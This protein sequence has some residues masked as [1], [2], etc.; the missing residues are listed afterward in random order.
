MP[1]RDF[2]TSEEE[3]NEPPPEGCFQKVVHHLM[4][5]SLLIF[6][7]GSCIRNLCQMCVEIEDE[8]EANDASK[9]ASGK[10]KG[11]GEDQSP[12]K[13]QVFSPRV[14]S[15][16]V[17]LEGASD[18]KQHSYAKSA[19]IGRTPGLSGP[20]VSDKKLAASVKATKRAD[21]GK[22][23]KKKVNYVAKIFE[24]VIMTLI[25]ISSITLVI[26][27]P[28]SNPDSGLIIVVGYLDNCFTVY[29]TIEAAIKIIALGFLTTNHEMARKGYTA[30]IQNP[31]NIL[32]FIVVVASLFDFIVTIQL[33]SASDDAGSGAGGIQDSL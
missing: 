14:A 13:S 23:N 19:K 11:P 5:S 18:A 24:A 8:G 25:I 10:E 22:K 21:A 31:W 2:E 30:Y 9:A 16:S 17:P 20:A 3:F 28:I 6:P 4:N 33:S 27:R 32:D 12:D 29:F 7:Q 1:K 26:D 15:L